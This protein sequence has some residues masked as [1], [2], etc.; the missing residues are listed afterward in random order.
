MAVRYVRSIQHTRK[1]YNPA[2]YRQG[3]GECREQVLKFL[4]HCPDLPAAARGKI[5]TQVAGA[6]VDQTQALPN[7]ATAA[8]AALLSPGHQPLLPQN[9]MALNPGL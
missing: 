4:V 8:A 7:P 2:S 3:F 9:L 1:F 5:L 6:L